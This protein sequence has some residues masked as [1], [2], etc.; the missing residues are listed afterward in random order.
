MKIFSSIA[1]EQL[2]HLQ[3]VHENLYQ[4]LKPAN[5]EQLQAAWSAASSMA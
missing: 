4:A 5:R 3:A 1:S 2:T